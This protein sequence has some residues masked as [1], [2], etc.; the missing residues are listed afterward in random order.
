MVHL[1]PRQGVAI[2]RT[3]GILRAVN[4]RCVG[5]DRAHDCLLSRP[6]LRIDRGGCDVIRLANEFGNRN[7]R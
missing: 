2:V 4:A 5:T 1:V 3:Y 7:V 6:T